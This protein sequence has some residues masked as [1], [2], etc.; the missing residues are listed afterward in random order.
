[1]LEQ[2]DTEVVIRSI[3]SPRDDAYV[4]VGNGTDTN[5]RYSSC[6]VPKYAI[7]SIKSYRI[8]FSVGEIYER[9]LA[10]EPMRLDFDDTPAIRYRSV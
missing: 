2:F 8:F 4:N 3:S 6:L 1:M 10:M 7:R 9:M 5:R